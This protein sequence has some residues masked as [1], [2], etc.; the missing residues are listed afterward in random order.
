MLRFELVNAKCANE[1]LKKTKKTI[2]KQY[3]FKHRRSKYYIWKYTYSYKQLNVGRET[4]TCNCLHWS[5]LRRAPIKFGWFI[6]L[7][8]YNININIFYKQA[9]RSFT[10]PI[11]EGT[12][13][14]KGVVHKIPA[15]GPLRSVSTCKKIFTLRIHCSTY[16]RRNS[17]VQ[18][19]T[20]LKTQ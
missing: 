14:Y 6:E 13:R 11:L 8:S 10:V 7:K 15:R 12:N 5:Q 16:F 9:D 19:T 17:I 18:K 20:Y 3:M 2:K 1:L 4:V